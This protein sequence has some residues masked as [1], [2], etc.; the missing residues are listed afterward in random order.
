MNNLKK[1]AL[2]L[3]IAIIAVGFSAFTASKTEK[4]H[5]V[6]KTYY[7]VGNEYVDQLPDGLECALD[8]QS[9]TIVFDGINLPS[10]SSFP[11]NTPPPPTNPG[12]YTT[13]KN[14]MNRS[15]Q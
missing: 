14:D 13:T 15:W 4:S 9:C 1:T 3:M 5:L 8:D 2:G 10:V 12:D 11:E 6:S 7:H